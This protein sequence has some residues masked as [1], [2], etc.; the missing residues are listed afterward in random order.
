MN[1]LTKA[2]NPFYDFSRRKLDLSNKQVD[3]LLSLGAKASVD[4]RTINFTVN[5]DVTHSVNIGLGHRSHA[6]RWV[7]TF[8]S[9]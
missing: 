1:T 6:T 2:F 7:N 4:G 3:E 9:K 8:N 5:G